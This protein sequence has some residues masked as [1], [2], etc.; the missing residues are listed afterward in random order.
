MKIIVICDE[1][2]HEIGDESHTLHG[3]EATLRLIHEEKEE[4]EM[5][6]YLEVHGWH[7]SKALYEHAVSQ[8]KTAAGTAP[9]SYN[10]EQVEALL[11][12]YGVVVENDHGYDVCY[13]YAMARADYFGSSLTTD[14]QLAH[15]V[16]DYLDDHDG[17]SGKALRHYIADNESRGVEIDWGKYI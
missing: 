14:T 1:P 16:K 17:Y 7:F 4:E 15:Y 2:H 6:E 8:M 5:K 3:S 9:L 13:V 12:Q 10:K 11:R